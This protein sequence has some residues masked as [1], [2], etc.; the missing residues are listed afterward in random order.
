MVNAI[1]RTGQSG[2]IDYSTVQILLAVDNPVVRRGLNDAFQHAGFN[3][4]TESLDQVTFQNAIDESSFDLIIMNPEIG[5][6]F[7]APMIA[8]MRADRIR[9]HPFPIVIMLLAE[10]QKG[11]IGKVI[12]CGPDAIFLLPVAP[13][14]LLDRIDSFAAHRKPFVVTQDYIGPDRRKEA[15][16]GTEQIPLLEVPNPVR[17]RTRRAPAHL[18]QSEIDTAKIQLNTLKLE[19]YA[20]QFRWLD[21]AVN[22][23]FKQSEVDHAKLAAAARRM[24]QIAEDLPARLRGDLDMRMTGLIDELVGGADAVLRDGSSI[25]RQRLDGVLANCRAIA[26]GIQ[27]CLPSSVPTPNCC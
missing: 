10:S 2:K 12:D 20:V 16:P 24:K 23:L 13:G 8:E 21:R 14:S 19:R 3:R 6:F 5:G 9:H 26:E 4:C 7:L 17:A 22:T 15:R 18:L 1:S 25:N 11:Y 27:G